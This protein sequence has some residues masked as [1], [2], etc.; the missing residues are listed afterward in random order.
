MAE[1][2]RSF[3]KIIKEAVEEY[4]DLIHVIL[5]PRQVGKTT[6]INQ[7]V[8]ESKQNVH[9]FS[10]DG[11]FMKS[12]A[13]L[14]EQWHVARSLKKNSLLIIDE[15]QKVENWSEVL[16]KL[17]DSQ[18]R[19]GE[20]SLK[21]IVLGSSSLAIQKGLSESLVGR[22]YLHPVYHWDFKESQAAFGLSL[23]SYLKF[24]G[25]P[26]SYRFVKKPNE[27]EHFVR[28]SIVEP[29][30]GRDI[31]SIARVRSPS[32]FKQCFQIAVGYTGQVISYTK[33]LGQLQDKGNTDLI[34]NYL[35]LFEGAFLIKQIPKYSEKKYLTRVSSPKIIS[36]CPA[37]YTAEI[38]SFVEDKQMGH[39][40]ESMIGAELSKLP[41]ELFFWRDG[42]FEVD[43]IWK[44][45]KNI[46]A[47]EVKWSEKTS[48]GL[49]EFK[50]R[51][52]RAEAL[53]INRENFEAV[54]ERLRST[55]L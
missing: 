34:K 21:M 8:K 45:G 3:V 51:Y 30:L 32:L 44:H 13:W 20:P 47:I 1:F 37:L 50:R 19:E 17:W 39:L 26:G 54:L 36:L 31:L 29:V 10:A 27:W 42:N 22:F 12:P 7:L 40:F 16:K 35:D 14:E 18:K 33:L 48:R 28:T 38:S 52:P 15:I 55:T 11:D 23:E 4:P 25:Y 24:G 49:S 43:F 53:I 46:F 9:Y 2:R 6:G 41:G 5:G